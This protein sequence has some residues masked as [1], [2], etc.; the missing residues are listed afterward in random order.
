[1]RSTTSIDPNLI[2]AVDAG[3]EER[4]DELVGL[5]QAWVRL[6]TVCV[7]LSPESER[8]DNEEGDLQA[9]IAERLAKLGATVDQWEPDPAA[10]RD[11]PMMPP[12]HHGANRPLTVGV[13]PGAGSGRSLIINGHIDVVDSGDRSRW[14]SDPFGGEL[15]D[16]RI[17]GRGAVDMKGGPCAGAH[18]SRTVDGD[19]RAAARRSHCS[20][21]VSARRNQSTV[22]AG[23]WRRE[24]D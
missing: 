22:L 20:R 13:V 11:H 7:D 18:R 15:R 2:E 24:R 9:L 17:Y 1:M 8:R 21:P 12:W 23:G 6:N 3:I 16:G 4:A 10:L 14:A 5:V 19:A